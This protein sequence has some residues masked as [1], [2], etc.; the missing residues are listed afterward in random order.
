MLAYILQNYHPKMK[1]DDV[2]NTA[3]YTFILIKLTRKCH[4]F[5]HNLL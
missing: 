2:Y 3:T 5:H 4:Q 1:K